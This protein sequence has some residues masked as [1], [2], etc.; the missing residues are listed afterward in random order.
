MILDVCPLAL[1]A[2][3]RLLDSRRGP[4]KLRMVSTV[5]AENRVPLISPRYKL[6]IGTSGEA[7][8]TRTPSPSRHPS[9]IN[10]QAA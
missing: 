9:Q 3:L 7:L 8:S 1:L 6:T 2:P 4:N 10:I 5:M